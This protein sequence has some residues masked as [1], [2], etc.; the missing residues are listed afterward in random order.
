[1]KPQRKSNTTHEQFLRLALTEPATAELRLIEFDD[2]ERLDLLVTL[3]TATVRTYF[4]DRPPSKWR[5]GATVRKLT[6][7]FG[8][9][10]RKAI[11][12]ILDA[13]FDFQAMG[14]IEGGPHVHQLIIRISACLCA[15]R[16]WNARKID[17]EVKKMLKTIA[18]MSRKP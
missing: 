15:W 6:S 8:T 10:H 2:D 18:L 7:L 13:P 17:A 9:K 11:E 5:R 16:K 3:M 12:I 1:M 14:A 4:G